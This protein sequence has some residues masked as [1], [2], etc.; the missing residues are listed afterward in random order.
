MVFTPT[1]FDVPDTDAGNN[2]GPPGPAGAVGTGDYGDVFGVST[3]IAQA[4]VGLAALVKA[5]PFPTTGLSNNTTP[6]GASSSITVDVTGDWMVYYSV[7]FGYSVGS[8]M[9]TQLFVNSVAVP[10]VRCQH[11]GT[12]FFHTMSARGSVSLTAGD[13][14]EVF[15][16]AAASGT[17]TFFDGQLYCRRLS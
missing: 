15:V 6:S 8:V 13:V 7:T 4:L 11:T 16:G 1:I 14:L 9:N 5:S 2:P 17:V 10:Q 12:I 3:A